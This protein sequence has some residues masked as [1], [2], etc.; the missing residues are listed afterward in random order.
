[1]S[2]WQTNVHNTANFLVERKLYHFRDVIRMFS[3]L[4]NIVFLDL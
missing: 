2:K 3:M 1:M 4:A